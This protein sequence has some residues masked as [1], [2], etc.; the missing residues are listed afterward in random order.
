LVLLYGD[1]AA[2]VKAVESAIQRV[3]HRN[4]EKLFDR[5]IRTTTPSER[6]SAWITAAER[7]IAR[8]DDRTE[9]G[10]KAPGTPAQTTKQ[11]TP[12]SQPGPSSLQ[13]CAESTARIQS[14]S[15]VANAKR[16]AQSATDLSSSVEQHASAAS[17]QEKAT[18]SGTRKWQDIE[19]LF[20]SDD[21]VQIHIRKKPAETL[22]Y[23]EFG[24]QD[25]RTKNPNT[26]WIALRQIA[27][28]NGII[29]TQTEAGVHWVKF[30]K[31]VQEIRKVLRNYFKIDRDPIVFV[32]NLGYRAQFKIGCGPSFHR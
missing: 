9:S 6:D 27:Q 8:L 17:K 1:N 16:Q 31:R 4:A 32:E 10:V 30:E 28:R 21:R 14:E 15:E 26:A 22:N 13:S 5:Y 2:L 7:S 11:R 3:D 19:I 12:D 29:R 18:V 24:F 25:N 20:L 23:A